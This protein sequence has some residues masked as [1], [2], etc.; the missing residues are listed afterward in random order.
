MPGFAL[1]NPH[2]VI[3]GAL[4]VVLLGVT[5][6]ARMPVDV[7][8][9]LKMPAV[10]VATFYPG[11]PPLEIERDITTRFERF[12]TLASDI[13]HI[14]SRSLPGVSIIRVFF[15]P[16]ANVDAAA[17]S[18]ANLA[19]ADLRHLPPG[20]LPPLV[21]KSD[22]SSLPVT[23]VTVAG[24]GFSE[25]QLR[26]QAQYNVRNQLATVAGASVPPPFGGKYRQIMVYADRKALEARGLTPMDVVHALN[27]ANLIIPA[28]DAKIGNIDY[29]VRS[30]SH[31]RG[32][33]GHRSRA[34]PGRSRPGAG[35]G[36][37]C[38]PRRGR[39]T[40]PAERGAHRRSALR[41]RAGPEARRNA[42]TIAVVDGVRDRPAE[43]LRAPE[44]AC[45]CSRSS[46]SRA[47][48]ATAIESSA[49]RR[50]ASAAVLAS[51]MILLFLGSLRVDAGDLPIDPA[52]GAG[53]GLRAVPER[54]RRSNV[55]DAGR[56]C[57]GD[58]RAWST[59]R[60]WCWRTSAA[61]WRR[62]RARLRPP[63]DGRATRSRSRCWPRP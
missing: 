28:G 31:D 56:I 1:R 17:A 58:R 32:P 26:D 53:G 18:I 35:A 23:L 16:D 62:A 47:T 36:R 21:L 33:D 54:R 49:A 3:V 41:L 20:T 34:G 39:G 57:A 45:T 19:M 43:G 38:R 63:R 9:N 13:E 24:E 50:R 55:D 11:M 30:N 25:A 2:T 4:V 37:R 27:D 10:V 46:T 6:F 15:N 8:P 52:L 59:T 5:A 61:T 22:A 51:L 7:F 40:D 12:F 60:W 42:N 29:F 14:E 48:S 44:P